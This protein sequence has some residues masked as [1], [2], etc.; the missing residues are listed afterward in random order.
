LIERRESQP[1]SD[2]SPF[3]TTTAEQGFA[4][5][6]PQNPVLPVVSEQKYNDCAN[7]LGNSPAPGY[8]Q[9][10][11]II[12][13]SALEATDATLLAVTWAKELSFDFSPVSNYRPEDGGWDVGPLQTATTYYD[14]SPFTDGLPNPLGTTRSETERF[15]GNSY[16]SLRVG[17]RALNEVGSRSRS[18]AD[19][20]G[21]YRAG[22]RKPTSYRTRANE[23]NSLSKGYD[24]FFNCLKK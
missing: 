4:Y 1:G 15:N 5:N 10:A 17:A 23:F 12:G 3:T 11:A 18:R 8:S 6:E 14:K 7:F 22:S 24:A 9:T 19:A 16:S 2:R 21:L 20:A 13:T